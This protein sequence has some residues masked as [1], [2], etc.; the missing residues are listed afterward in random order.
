[1][2]VFQNTPEPAVDLIL[3]GSFL[4]LSQQH[5]QEA[6]ISEPRNPE[7]QAISPAGTDIH[8]KPAKACTEKQWSR[9][10][11]RLP[12]SI[13]NRLPVRFIF[14]NNYFNAFY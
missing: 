10:C 2:E 4:P 1:M 8:E 6:G 14:D 7:E 9:P 3:C 12:A 5:R 13:I 11:H